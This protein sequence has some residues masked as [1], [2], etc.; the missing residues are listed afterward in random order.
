[1]YVTVHAHLEHIIYANSS[2]LVHT[3]DTLKAGRSTIV[4]ACSP[5]SLNYLSVQIRFVTC[6]PDDF[7]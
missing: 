1:M 4:V 2:A 5:I 7:H 6:G 3:A